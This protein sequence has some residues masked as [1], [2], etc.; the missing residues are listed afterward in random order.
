VDRRHTFGRSPG[1]AAKVSKKH[2]SPTLAVRKES[3]L[4][5]RDRKGVGDVAANGQFTLTNEQ[6][7]AY[8]ALNPYDRF[9]DGRP[10]VPDDLLA[11]VKDLVIEEV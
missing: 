3:E 9:S 4:A 7:N 10:K 5:N 6:M 1:P 8:T 2:R 11:K